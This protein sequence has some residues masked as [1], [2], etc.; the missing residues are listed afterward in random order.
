MNRESRYTVLKISDVAGAL[1]SDEKMELIRLEEKTNL[2]R[3][4]RGKRPLK[5]VVV[6]HDWPEYE[7]TWQAIEKRVTSS[8]N[9]NI[10][11][12]QLSVAFGKYVAGY[13]PGEP[14]WIKLDE[15]ALQYVMGE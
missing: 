4:C 1:R 7:P 8:V 6:E 3:G 10:S 2:H 9:H 13:R 5:C 11:F 12:Q 15:D 14:G